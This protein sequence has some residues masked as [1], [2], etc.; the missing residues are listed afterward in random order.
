LHRWCQPIWRCDHG[1]GRESLRHD[2][3]GGYYYFF[4]GDYSRGT[5]FLLA[6][7]ANGWNEAVLY[8]FCPPGS[9]CRDGAH[10][11]ASL[12]MDG[13]GNIYGTS[14][15]G[16]YLSG[17]NYS[18]GTVFELTP[19]G[20]GWSTRVLYSFCSQSNC[21]DGASPQSSLVIDAAGNL[22]G[23][24]AT[25]GNEPYAC[26]VR[27]DGGCGTVFQLTRSGHTLS[28]SVAGGNGG[29]IWSSPSGIDCSSTCIANFADGAPVTL[30]AGEA[31]AW[32]FVGWGGACSGLGSCTL[33]MDADKSVS[34]TF[35]TLF[36]AVVP[37]TASTP[38]DTPL[39]PPLIAPIPQ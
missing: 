26:Y 24:A 34:A 27:Y 36:G 16:T 7:A 4:D 30:G 20:T 21:S 9:S 38:A 6:P 14:A 22:Y 28:V 39:P 8:S 19:T 31:T 23:T 18:Y 33:T 25:G 2:L 15:G 32:G 37:S 10:P 12:V 17:G 11:Y 29:R 35:T 13:A 3:G 5:V 1:S